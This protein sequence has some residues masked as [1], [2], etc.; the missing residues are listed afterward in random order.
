MPRIVCDIDGTVLEQGQPVGPVIEW[1]K[2]NSEEVIFL[3]NR[4][5]SE[6][7]RTVSDLERTGISYERLVMND[8]E[9][10]APAFKAR[11]VAEWLADGLRIDYFIDDS[12][13]NRD[14]VEALGVDVV[15]PADIV[16]SEADKDGSADAYFSGAPISATPSDMTPELQTPEAKLKA[17]IV[18]AEAAVAE[19][20]TLRKDFEA[21]TAKNLELTANVDG[22]VAEL[23]SKVEAAEAS[24]AALSSEK[25]ELIAKVEALEAASKSAA[26]LAAEKVAAIGLKEPLPVTAATPAGKDAA[27]ILE[28]YAALTDRDERLAF[29]E[30]N[31]R[32]IHAAQLK[33]NA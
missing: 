20:D 8:G 13:A 24:V 23:V 7:D 31:K 10:E 9:E 27:S 26:A 25:A 14:A 6:R 5:E 33:A 3:T 15:D 4:P 12:E 32:A 17:A 1:V 28:Q 19:R 11:K 21:L 29:Y 2:A 22:K 16:E 18:A 30:A